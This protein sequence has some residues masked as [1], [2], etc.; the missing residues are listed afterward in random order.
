MLNSCM[1]VQMIPT[2]S[3]KIHA[4]APA[5]VVAAHL[6]AHAPLPSTKLQAGKHKATAAKHHALLRAPEGEEEDRPAH[7]AQGHHLAPEAAPAGRAAPAARAAQHKRPSAGRV[8]Q[9]VQQIHRLIPTPL[10]FAHGV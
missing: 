10:S 1:C 8:A 3:A 7:N 2:K 4:H 9:G 6:P 5:P